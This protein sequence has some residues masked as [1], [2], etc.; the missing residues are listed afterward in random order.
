MIDQGPV[1]GE[2]RGVAPALAGSLEGLVGN[3]RIVQAEFLDANGAIG[4]SWVAAVVDREAALRVERN[5]GADTAEHV[6]GIVVGLQ[7]ESPWNHPGIDHPREEALSDVVRL[8]VPGGGHACLGQSKDPHGQPDDMREEDRLLG[9]ELA[10]WI[11]EEAQRKCSLHAGQVRLRLV[12]DAAAPVLARKSAEVFGENPHRRS[13]EEMLVACMQTQVQHA[14]DAERVY[15]ANGAVGRGKTQGRCE[16]V[17][18]ID[19]FAEYAKPGVRQPEARFGNVPG[20]HANSWSEAVVPDFRVL[21][22]RPQPLEAL[23]AAV[24]AH[25]AVHRESRI[26]VEQVPHQETA[27]E[28]GRAGDEDVAEVGGGNSLGGRRTGDCF[29][30]E[31]A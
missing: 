9:N 4:G 2:R 17:Y 18:G 31:A 28:A 3:L 12:F 10:P 21:H 26:P 24:A 7:R 25:D 29:A 5:L 15:A 20:V 11:S 16:M 13:V 22:V 30:N 27:E 23:L 19:L 1:S 14:S 8:R 6:H